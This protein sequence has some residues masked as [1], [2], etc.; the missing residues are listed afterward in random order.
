[1][2]DE[3]KNEAEKDRNLSAQ[4]IL[5]MLMNM[6]PADL[7]YADIKTMAV[8]PSSLGLMDVEFSIPAMTKMLGIEDM[9]LEMGLRIVKADGTTPAPSSHVSCIN[10][11]GQMIISKLLHN[12]TKYIIKYPNVFLLFI[13]EV[14]VL[15]NERDVTEKSIGLY[16]Y[17]TYMTKMITHS[18]EVKKFQDTRTGFHQDKYNLAYFYIKLNYKT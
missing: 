9:Y 14:K 6:L 4:L 16:H 12:L 18:P 5:K 13:G 17:A 2:A 15:L 10:D 8:S 11:I 1:M 3:A 7:R